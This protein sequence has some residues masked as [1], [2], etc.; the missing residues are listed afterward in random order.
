MA[1]YIEKQHEEENDLQSLREVCD[2]VVRMMLCF[3]F[4]EFMTALGLLNKVCRNGVDL[5]SP[6]LVAC[7]CFSNARNHV[8]TRRVRLNRKR[9]DCEVPLYELSR[10]RTHE[11]HYSLLS[12]RQLPSS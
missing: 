12:A 9:Q 5:S 8:A 4:L 11:L 1:G 3:P 6:G 2:F 10:S 7:F